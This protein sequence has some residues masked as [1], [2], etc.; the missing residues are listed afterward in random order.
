[1]EGKVMNNELKNL[2][3]DQAKKYNRLSNKMRKAN[4]DIKF[5]AELEAAT[6]ALYSSSARKNYESENHR[7]IVGGVCQ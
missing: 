5:L 2:Y 3:E 7:E 4:I 1:M 6:I